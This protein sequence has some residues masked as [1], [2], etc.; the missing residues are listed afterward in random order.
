MSSLF[1]KVAG[2]RPVTVLKI[3]SFKGIFKDFP[4]IK[5]YFFQC[6]YSLEIASYKEYLLVAATVPTYV[7]NK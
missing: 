2:C 3:N 1:S 7:Y 4:N 5:S 6:L